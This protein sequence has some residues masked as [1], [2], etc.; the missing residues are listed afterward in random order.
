MGVG[1]QASKKLKQIDS[2]HTWQ[3]SGKSLVMAV[4]W[5]PWSVI[6]G[7]VVQNKNTGILNNE[8]PCKSAPQPYSGCNTATGIP[9]AG[10]S[11]ATPS[12]GHGR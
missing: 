1:V 12:V 6:A 11:R 9:P 10:M 4:L 2:T 7:E 8:W 3:L 5:P